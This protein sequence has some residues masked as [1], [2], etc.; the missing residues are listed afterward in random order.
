MPIGGQRIVCSTRDAQHVRLSDQR[1]GLFRAVF[2]ASSVGSERFVH[3]VEHCKHATE[4]QLDRR[5]VRLDRSSPLQ[6]HDC[7]FVPTPVT[8]EP[9]KVNSPA[10]VFR[11]ESYDPTE[12][13][14]GNNVLLVLVGRDGKDSQ[15]P[16]I[17]R[18]TLQYRIADLLG[19]GKITTV[20]E[21]HGLG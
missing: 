19:F 7:L 2:Q 12:E 13:G 4:H 6:V 14:L 5:I 1:S 21:R 11:R 18:F 15:R 10:S 9:R 8:E 3:A 17:F 16:T 20:A